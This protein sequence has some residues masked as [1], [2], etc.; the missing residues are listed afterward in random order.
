VY[1]Y[2]LT[3]GT[4]IP[5]NYAGGTVYAQFGGTGTPRVSSGDSWSVTS[6]SGG[7]TSTLNGTF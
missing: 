6:T 4:S 1:S 7:L 3:A 2:V 5:A